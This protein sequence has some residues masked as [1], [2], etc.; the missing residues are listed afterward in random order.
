VLITKYPQSCLVVEV[1]AARL[2]IDPGSFLTARFDLADL[3]R[4]DAVLVTH[5]HADHLDPQVVAP[6]RER[7]IELYGNDDVAELVGGDA[8]TTIR[9]GE[10]FQAAGV[11][12]HPHDL[13]HVV[14][15]DGSPGPP[16]TGFLVDGTLFHPGDGV[17][18]TGLSA[19][20]VAA[21]I[22]GPSISFREAYRFVQQLGAST[23]VP[24]HYDAFVADPEHFARVCDLAEVVV[25]A[26]GATTEV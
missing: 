20:V 6:L 24:V 15:V 18:L 11:E 16:N 17:E 21:P 5:R 4:I 10:P 23:V 3:G 7:G 12:I 2:L 26:D 14:M 9:S 25:L 19:R 8:I 1:G 13:P 22:C